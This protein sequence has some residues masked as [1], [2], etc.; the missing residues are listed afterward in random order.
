MTTK[1][2]V[3]IDANR[4]VSPF[5]KQELVQQIDN[6]DLLQLPIGLMVAVCS[7]LGSRGLR[8][9][10][11]MTVAEISEFLDS[12]NQRNPTKTQKSPI[13]RD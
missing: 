2:V 8:Y 7:E 5:E 11:D 3:M 6:S 12:I 1:Y 9:R 10:A 13:S 4:R